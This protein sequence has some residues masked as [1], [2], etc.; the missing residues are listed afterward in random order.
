MKLTKRLSS[1]LQ[2]T[3]GF[4]KLA[5]IGTDHALLPIAA[6][7][8]GFVLNALAIDNKIGPFGIAYNN[9][10][11]SNVSNKVKVILGDGLEKI[12]DQVDVVVISGMGGSLIST[13]LQ[14]HS[15]R[16]VK[17]FI[18][19]PNNDA[20]KIRA[21]LSSIDYYI[22]DELVIS[23]TNKFYD[24]IILEKGKPEYSPLQIMFGPVNLK[25]KS[26]YFVLRIQKELNRLY[27]LLEELNDSERV[28]EIKKTIALLE[29]ALKWKGQ[30]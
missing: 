2:Y 23:E 28:S 3:K 5:D 4:N 29:E 6:V 24:L 21:V 26:H 7:Q 19:Q 30:I 27:S 17:R 13:I 10:N 11:E 15:C 25:I 16:F 1:C 12:D 9:V 20:E 8:E 18:L 22:I 14:N